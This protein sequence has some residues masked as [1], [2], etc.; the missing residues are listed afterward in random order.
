MV[1]KAQLLASASTYS[2]RTGMSLA[3]LATL[4]VNDGKCFVRLENGGDCSTGTYEKFMD[5][6]N[7]N[8]PAA[9]GEVVK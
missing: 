2:Q 8:T 4:V 5:Y 9:D 3:R 7:E 1:L 6:L